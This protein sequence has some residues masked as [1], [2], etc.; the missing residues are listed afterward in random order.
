MAQYRAITEGFDLYNGWDAA[1]GIG[2]ASVWTASSGS[3]VTIVSGRFGG[4]AVSVSVGGTGGIYR[5]T[6]RTSMISSGVAVRP[7]LGVN[8]MVVIEY[9]STS[10][11]QVSLSQTST[12]ALTI[13]RGGAVLATSD[14]SMLPSSQWAYVEFAAAIST[15][16]GTTS[17]MVNGVE[18][19]QLTLSNVNTQNQANSD[20][21]FIYLGSGGGASQYDDLYVEVDGTAHIGEGRMWVGQVVS[22]I[23]VNFTPSAGTSNYANVDEVPVVATDYNYSASVGARDTFQVADLDFAPAAIYGVQITLNATKDEA[24]PRAMKNI[25]ISG[26]TEQIGSQFV[27]ALSANNWHND[28][29]ARNPDTDSPWTISDVNALKIG[30][31]I[32]A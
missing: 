5:P 2:A 17:V 3:G 23:A 30:Y 16:T 12:G 25:L 11:T 31:E 6:P 22:D 20:V 1:S 24:G 4:Q 21:D 29:W 26:A 15:T 14:I 8:D 32:S 7:S 13:S 10:G 27:L 9:R 19:S 28:F 18:V